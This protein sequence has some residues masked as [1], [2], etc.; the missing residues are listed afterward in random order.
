VFSENQPEIVHKKVP[1]GRR[2]RADRR[3]FLTLL[4]NAFSTFRIAARET[5][6]T[7][8]V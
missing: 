2:Q 5:A 4:L 3:A 6:S 1:K 8:F 7:R